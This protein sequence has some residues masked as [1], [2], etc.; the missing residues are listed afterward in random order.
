MQQ[1]QNKAIIPQDNELNH[2]AIIMDGNRRWAKKYQKPANKGHQQ[3]AEA[4]QN[5]VKYC[6][7]N[8]IAWLTVYAFSIENWQRNKL[9]V[10]GLM[11]LLYQFLKNK[12]NI[13]MEHGV[14]LHV[15]GDLELLPLKQKKELI[16]VIEET[17]N[18]TNLT[19]TLAL[20]YGGRD[21]ILRV[22]RKIAK[23]VENKN[24]RANHIDNSVFESYLDTAGMPDPDLLIRTSGEKRLSN[25]LL[26]Q[27]SYAELYFTDVLWPDFDEVEFKKAVDCYYSRERRF[28]QRTEAEVS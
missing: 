18:N 14:K 22:A 5:T 12:S 26:W 20:S 3:G 17:K 4:L 23:D 13:L 19:F 8:K 11:E 7:E 6:L 24:L 27:L 28:G 21:E 16:K 1:A 10:D 2:V 25:F 9:E 15:I